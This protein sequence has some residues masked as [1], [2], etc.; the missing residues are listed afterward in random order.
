MWNESAP[1]TARRRP[2]Q[3]TRR[4]LTALPSAGTNPEPPSW[5]THMHLPQPPR[6]YQLPP[7]CFVRG[8][9]RVWMW[10]CVGVTAIWRVHAQSRVPLRSTI[11]AT[12]CGVSVF[13]LTGALWWRAAPH[14]PEIGGD[15]MTT[16]RP[17]SS[18]RTTFRGLRCLQTP[19]GQALAAKGRKHPTPGRG[20]GNQYDVIRSG[21]PEQTCLPRT[22]PEA[23]AANGRA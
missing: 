1:P 20:H 13:A 16:R 9:A 14:E 21:C 18:E 15:V 6:P 12:C 2:L 19:F 23:L 3:M 11:L 5:T 22:T 10:L 8:R 17:R 7:A 4:H